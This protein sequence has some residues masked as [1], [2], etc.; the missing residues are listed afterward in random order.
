MFLSISKKLGD[1]T[2][3]IT[4]VPTQQW[5]LLHRSGTHTKQSA[6]DS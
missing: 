2:F 1:L 6:H 3:E 5:F 4:L